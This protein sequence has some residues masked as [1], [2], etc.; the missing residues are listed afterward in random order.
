MLSISIQIT[1]PDT[2]EI[3]LKNGYDYSISLLKR[4]LPFNGNET[5][6]LFVEKQD[7]KLI[8]YIGDKT[9]MGFDLKL[10]AYE[11]D[12]NEQLKVKS[13]LVNIYDIKNDEEYSISLKP[14]SIVPTSKMKDY[15]SFT[16]LELLQKCNVL[17]KTKFQVSRVWEYSLITSQS[18]EGKVDS[19]P[20]KCPLAPCYLPSRDL[21][22]AWCRPVGTIPGDY[23][24][25]PIC[26]ESIS[27]SRKIELTKITTDLSRNLNKIKVENNLIYKRWFGTYTKQRAAKVSKI[28][29]RAKPNKRCKTS[30]FM[31]TPYLTGHDGTEY[32]K[33]RFYPGSQMIC[34]TLFPRF[35]SAP[36]YGIDSK[37]G[38]LVH[39]YSHEYG[40]TVDDR[41]GVQSCLVLAKYYP[42]RAI[43][44]A[45]NYQYFV[46]EQW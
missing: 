41:Y 11:L 1:K 34:I 25:I 12:V 14:L 23:I 32:A 7:G 20:G 46:E 39:E 5:D 40:G 3:S 9:K 31:S 27:K 26:T 33:V 43:L 17:E 37:L 19:P 24:S 28:V 16:G 2:L 15:N 8:R 6:F 10:S 44:N 18:L 29:N 35:W 22:M 36:D 13:R 38:T 21:G 4:E 45:D 42:E 30:F